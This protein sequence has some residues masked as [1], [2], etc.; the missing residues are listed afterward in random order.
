MMQM[1]EQLTG[2]TPII[3]QPNCVGDCMCL[4]SLANP[5]A[6]GAGSE[7]NSV[8][9]GG[10]QA[11]YASFGNPAAGVGTAP[12]WGTLT[13]PCQVFIIVAPPATGLAVYSNY[14]GLGSF[15]SPL[16]GGGG[17]W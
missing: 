10:Y 11:P 3:F 5:Q 8:A 14:D 15:A 4:A 17:G 12:A 16:A 1:L 6:A 13:M 2:N 7:L 9:Q